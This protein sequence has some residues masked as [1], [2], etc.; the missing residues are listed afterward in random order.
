MYKI[1]SLSLLTFVDDSYLQRKSNSE[2]LQN[3]HDTLKL[4]EALGFTIHKGKSVL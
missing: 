3:F 1:L 2:S 4:L